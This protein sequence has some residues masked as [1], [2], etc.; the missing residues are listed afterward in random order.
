MQSD[1]IRWDDCPPKDRPL[2]IP[3]LSP[4]VSAPIVVTLLGGGLVGVH[5]HHLQRR[6]FP[7]VGAVEP[8]EG[9]HQGQASR[10][11]GYLAAWSRQ[12]SRLVIAELTL[13]AFADN[14]HL[15]TVKRPNLR[16]WSLRLE[17]SGRRC[18]SPVRAT[19]EQPPIN[20]KE[21]PLAFDVKAQLLHIWNRTR[22]VPEADVPDLGPIG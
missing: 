17:R 19:F 15:L 5:T 20:L 13:Q 1:R 18:N 11:K 21:V 14:Y 8:C 2:Y 9:C 7:C 4:R 3:I 6:T 12:S 16:G 22:A 10:W